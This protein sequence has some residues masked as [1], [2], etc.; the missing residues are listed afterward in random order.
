MK[1]FSHTKK[2]AIALAFVAGMS[3]VG[4]ASADS[5]AQ[6]TLSL[7]GLQ[8]LNPNGTELSAAQF[9][10][11]QVIDSTTLT[12]SV[13]GNGP[14]VAN[15]FTTIGG[16]PL[17]QHVLCVPSGCPGFLSPVASAPF[18]AIT[19]GPAA[20][21]GSLG[22][23]NLTG[24]PVSN[25][26]A[27][28][29]ASATAQ[30]AAL[31]E[32]MGT[33]FAQTASTLGLQT[34]FTF[35]LADSQTVTFDYNALVHL[36]ANVTGG[37]LSASSSVGWNINISTGGS[38]VF[39]WAPDGNSGSIVGG[40][41]QS[42]ACN[43][44]TGRSVFG[45]GSIAYDCTGTEEATTGTLTA[46][47]LYSLTLTHTDNTVVVSVPEPESVMLLGLGLAGIALARRRKARAA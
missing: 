15:S 11:L 2:T 42:D 12:P 4:T 46:G 39:S 22:A 9:S 27:P 24:A 31:S 35:A 8:F 37:G 44:N 7:T 45:S 25:L 23:S 13:N 16:T 3:V 10:Q 29:P 36:F 20:G 41:V 19:S 30:V 14:G 40:T 38:T 17:G 21:T 43:L 32:Y 47:T 26:I 1:T 5:M 6:S 18:T 33:G 28:G 34:A